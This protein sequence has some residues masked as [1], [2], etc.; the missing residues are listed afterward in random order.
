MIPSQYFSE[1]WTE[2]G[3]FVFFNGHY[4]GIRD[5]EKSDENETSLRTRGAGYL[6][7]DGSGIKLQSL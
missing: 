1:R 5:Q 3:F 7:V 6:E 4:A 2:L